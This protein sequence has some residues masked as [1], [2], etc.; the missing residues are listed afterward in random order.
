MG[1]LA[2]TKTGAWLEWKIGRKKQIE[3]SKENK[4]KTRLAERL[5]VAASNKTCRHRLAKRT[6]TR[7]K[8]KEH[9]IK[10][11]ENMKDRWTQSRKRELDKDF[12]KGAW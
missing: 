1:E 12:K 4:C 6:Q 9:N 10:G 5:N 3:T 2:K 7:H 11:D 8:T